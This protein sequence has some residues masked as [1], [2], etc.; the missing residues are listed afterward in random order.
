M[1]DIN[2]SSDKPANNEDVFNLLVRIHR[3]VHKVRSFASMIRSVGALQRFVYER[4][5]PNKG[6]FV[7]DV[8]VRLTGSICSVLHL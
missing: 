6:G 5:G 8:K 7:L 4:L 1:M 3:L 2:I